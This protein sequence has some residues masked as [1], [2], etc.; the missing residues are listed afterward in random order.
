M[1]LV[2]GTTLGRWLRERGPLPLDQHVPFF[3]RVAEVVQTAHD[4]G[5][6]HRDLKPSNV[7]M[8]ER[9]GQLLPKLVDFGIAKLVDDATPAGL[10]SASSL[11]AGGASARQEP[12]ARHSAAAEIATL[13]ATSTSPPPDRAAQRWP[14]RVDFALGSPPYM[15]P[16][17]WCDAESVGTAADVYALGVMAYEALAGRR[18]F[19]AGTFTEYVALHCHADVPPL[20]DGFS[21]A[22]DRVFQRALAKRPEDRWASALDLAAALRVASG[23]AA[24]LPRLDDGVRDAWLADAP[25]PLA[26]SIAALDGAR[27]A[28][29]AQ[30]A[31]HALVGNLLRYLV[32]LALATRAQVRADREEPELLELVRTAR[33]RDLR[34]DERVRL[35]RLLVQPLAS[36]RGAHPIPALID[37]VTPCARDDGEDSDGLTPI[38]TLLPTSEHAGTDDIVRARLARL[39]PE[40]TRLLRRLAFVL[41]Y[42]LV[43]P[44]GDAAERWTGLRRPRRAVAAVRGGALVDGHPMLLDREGRVRVDL[45][46]LAQAVAPTEA[47]EPELFLFDGPGRHGARLIAAPAGFEHHDAGVWEWLAAGMTV[48]GPEPGTEERPPYLG[49]S[50][51]AAGDTDRFV[52]RER[53]VDR[54]VNRLRRRSLQI[55]VG[56]SGA[57]KSSFLHAGV[58]PGLPAGWR[59]VAFRPGSAPLATLAV[60][61]AAAGVAGDLR[62]LLEASPVAAAAVVAQAATGATLVI[63]IDQLEELFTQCTSAAER[64]QFA[65]V[66]A[67]LAASPEAPIRVIGAIRDDFLMQLEGLAPLRSLLSPSLVLLGNPSRDEL[68]RIVVEP[69]RRAGYALSDPELARDMVNAVA[70]HPGALALLSFTAS[71]LWELR[72][73]RF[74]Q[75]TRSA[76]DA[77]GGVA[78]ALGQHAEATLAAL[79]ATEQRTVREIFRH[80]VTAEGTRASITPG[81]LRQRLAALDPAAVVDTLVTARLLTIADSDGEPQLELIHEAL[82]DAWPRLQQWVRDD[83]EGTRLR[84][85]L[86]TAARHWHDRGR[87]R[88]LVWRDDALA[89]LERWMRRASGGALSELEAAFVEA[90][91]RSA[92]RAVWTRRA[93][94]LTALIVVITFAAVRYRSTVQT[95]L[96]EDLAALSVRQRYVEQGRE[97]LLRGNSAEALVY[98]AEA[99]RRGDDSTSVNFMLARAAQPLLAERLRLAAPSGRVLSARFSRDGERIVTAGDAGAHVWDASTG[100]R[101]FDLPHTDM[102]YQAIYSPDGAS[103]IT[104]GGDGFVKIW[105]AETGGLIRELRHGAA[106]GPVRY[107]MLALSPDGHLVAAIDS[108]GRLAHVWDGRTGAFVVELPNDLADEPSLTFSADGHWL[109]TTGGNDARVFDVHTWKQVVTLTGP[110]INVLSFDPTGPRLATASRLGDASIWAIPSGTRVRHLRE[111]GELIDQI[112][113]APNGKMIATASRDGTVQVWGATSGQL[114]TQSRYHRDKI[115]SIEF[116]LAST[117][118]L[119]AGTEGL[120]IVSDVATGTPMS[121][122]EGSP[123]PVVAHFD[124]S[125]RRV[126]GASRDGATRIWD[127]GSLYRRW[128]SPPIDDDCGAFDS[129]DVDQ[130]FIA[131]S[132]K[133][134]GTHVWDTTQGHLVAE[135]PTVTPVGGDFQDAH[136]AVSAAGD[137]AAIARGDVVMILE[138][139]GGQLLR[140][141]THPAAVTAV[142]FARSG[143]DLVSGAVDG[144]LLLTRDDRE[145]FALPMLPGGVDLVGFLLGGRVVASGTRGQ[146]RVYEPDRGV[147]LAELPAPTRTATLRL[148]PDGLRLI[149]IPVETKAAPP[150][151]WDLERYRVVAHLDGHIGPV[152]SARFVRD[153][154]EILTGGV[155]GTARLWDGLT[156]QLRQTYSG[157]SQ[158]LLDAAL[159]PD[160]TIVVTAGGDGQLRFWDVVSARLLWTLQAH[161]SPI[162]AMRFDGADIV[163]Q[164]ASGEI[165]RW[166]LPALASPG[167]IDDL[168][169]C[170]P[171]RLDAATGAWVKQAPCNPA[172]ASVPPPPAH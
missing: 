59:S 38:L 144:S 99:R 126:V 56:P 94:W 37:L 55:V 143:H 115:R 63:V 138:L 45:W 123:T 168:V 48:V 102:V 154:H 30:D 11:A 87:P 20:G 122:L 25:Q 139:P 128:N 125:A 7:M 27:N 26:E 83:V 136:P 113:Y 52:G 93:L 50:A 104:A 121:V 107:Y 112:A 57:G 155:D 70:D 47:A 49:L 158:Y 62:S 98:L 159:T 72:D 43:V 65:A 170:L 160:G 75:L 130:R 153:G 117:L 36:V 74:R 15:S 151:L 116:D 156:G 4:H 10:A 14:L 169:R 95:G 172:P 64:G 163:T 12:P 34:S 35:L 119:S 66:V 135:L 18:P 80:L 90:S 127:A 28:H 85:Q 86:R 162:A 92:R 137:R 88:G 53:E 110:Q 19:H 3:E 134:R 78:G 33:R 31:A 8:I 97:A 21:P 161:K 61:L 157:S 67:E 76:Y 129:L 1:E 120:V 68:V 132:C 141:V 108:R 5:I 114:Q 140:A 96:A 106:D 103:I 39:V 142:A 17:Q 171:Q 109:A 71:R 32:A 54:F 77:M 145:P 149:T 79:S 69:A 146:L 51:F 100:R 148:S 81:E 105:D 58:V 42:L 118:V 41:D 91:R 101:L 2:R 23:T 82:V 60:R 147:I 6:V 152:F 164:A 84:D 131:I 165:S 124:R 150:V 166:Q 111:V 89:D 16:E 9:A 46:P 13:T 24:D 133:D 73:R 40:L 167:V 29:Q 44:R 22:L